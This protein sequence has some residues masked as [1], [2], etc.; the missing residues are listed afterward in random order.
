MRL[1]ICILILSSMAKLAL[2]SEA[3]SIPFIL[4]SGL[5]LVEAEVNAELGLYVFD[6][7][8]SDILINSEKSQG[9]AQFAT[10]NGY[11]LSSE[12]QVK[13]VNLAGRVMTNVAAYELDLSDV[14]DLVELDIAGILGGKLFSEHIIHIDFDNEVILLADQL[15]KNDEHIAVDYHL[16]DDVP[17]IDVQLE[18]QTLSFILDSGASAHF[19]DQRLAAKLLVEQTQ[20]RHVH[21]VSAGA[22][23]TGQSYLIPR[24]QIGD[25]H[26]QDTKMIS[27]QFSDLSSEVEVAGLIS[28]SALPYRHIIIDTERH[29]IYMR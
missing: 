13:S 28:I 26:I 5:M 14:A 7:G 12:V 8:A 2:A 6:T 20:A 15:E 4:Q 19:I 9:E 11:I 29:K 23:G 17:M 24:M 10:T 3:T 16:V 18:G 1:T 22:T 21:V 25:I 27:G